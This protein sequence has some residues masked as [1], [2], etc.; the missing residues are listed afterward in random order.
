MQKFKTLAGICFL[1]LALFTTN[2]NAAKR[3]FYE[4]KIYHIKNTEQGERVENYLK[5]AFIPAMHRAGFKHVGVFKPVLKDTTSGKQIYVLTT[6]KALDQLV[7]LHKTLEKDQKYLADGKD[8]LDAVYSNPP[9]ERIET[10]VL[11][12]FEKRPMLKASQLSGA[13]SDRIYELRSYE[14]HTEKIHRNKVRMFNDGDEM[15]IFDRL[16]FNPVFYG[17][18]VSGKT[19]PNLMYLTTFEHQ[20]SRD[21]HW[22]AFTNDEEWAKLKVRPEFQNNV[23]KNIQKFL[24]PTEYSDL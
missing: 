16:G 19:M 7:G 17:E 2:A 5:N 18:V 22:K 8:Y 6:Y 20:A 15:G 14:S 3:E 13:K 11:H 21:A 23:S 12:A 9:Y 10:T 4:I 24:Y 1:L